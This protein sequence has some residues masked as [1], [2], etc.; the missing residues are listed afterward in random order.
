MSATEMA[1][2]VTTSKTRK[3]SG[4]VPAQIQKDSAEATSLQ[5]EKKLPVA[6]LTIRVMNDVG[7]L[8]IDVVNGDKIRLGLLERNLPKIYMAIQTSQ[9]KET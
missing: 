2:Q 1:V 8:E 4:Q 7:D 6:I 5:Q 3:Y 9:R